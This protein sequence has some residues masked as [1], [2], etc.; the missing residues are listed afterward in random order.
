MFCILKAKMIEGTRPVTTQY[1]WM[2]R[3]V[4]HPSKN[5]LRIPLKIRNMCM[6]CGRTD[7]D[8]IE[9]CLLTE[10]ICAK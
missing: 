5:C 2:C 3:K 7:H 10:E 8:E 1:C 9:G 6:A 4:G